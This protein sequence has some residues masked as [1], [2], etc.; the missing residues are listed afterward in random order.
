MKVVIAGAHGQIA[1]LLTRSLAARGESVTG[2]IRNPDHA[3]DLRA[4]GSEPIVCD[5]EHADLESV[6]AAI[7]GAEAVVFAAGAGPGSGAA[8]KLTMDRDGAVKLI[9]AARRA[10]VQ[11]YL[12]VSAV[13]AGDPPA[14][15]DVM[16]VYLRAK[17]QADDA[18]AASELDWT[19]LRPGAL[20]NDPG[21]G[22]VRIDRDAFRGQVPRADV[23]AVIEAVLHEP[24]TIRTILYVNG[25]DEQ[26]ADALER[27]LAA[28]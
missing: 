2:L 8:R 1:R 17:A 12:M 9:D 14:G 22:R 10:G 21:A 13:G 25:G 28:V 3:D 6:A 19:I 23:A 20:T 4:D 18:L 7:S 11:R 15:D 27:A 16:S 24:R 26:V 5:L